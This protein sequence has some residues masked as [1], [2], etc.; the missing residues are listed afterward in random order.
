[1]RSL[2]LLLLASLVAF[3]PAVQAES[4]YCGSEAAAPVQGD[5]STCCCG[6]AGSC[7]CAS[8]PGH[9]PN[10]QDGPGSLSGCVCTQGQPQS[11]PDQQ[12]DVVLAEALAHEFPPVAAVPQ[13]VLATA[14][15]LEG[16]LGPPASRPLLI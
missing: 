13:R 14:P 16:D 15:R 4:C 8:C 11:G 3:A 9:E 5:Q 1:M 10:D 12:V 6:D 7:C 2:V